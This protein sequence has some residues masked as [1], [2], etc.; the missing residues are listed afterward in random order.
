M[1]IEMAESEFSMKDVLKNSEDFLV[2]A[3]NTKTPKKALQVKLLLDPFLHAFDQKKLEQET[4]FQPRGFGQ[5]AMDYFEQVNEHFDHLEEVLTDFASEINLTME[6]LFIHL[7]MLE[8]EKNKVKR[9]LENRDDM[10][11]YESFNAEST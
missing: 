2:R 1:L 10:V 3:A 6:Q 8:I 11:I 5:S 4:K 7:K 9:E